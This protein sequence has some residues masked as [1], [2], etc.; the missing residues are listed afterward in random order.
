MQLNKNDEFFMR[1]ALK[2]AQKAAEIGEIPVGAVIV[3]DNKIIAKAHNQTQ[4]L[5]DPTA[6]AEMICITAACHFM[7]AKYL[8]NS[9]LYV[10]LE[11]CVMCAGAIKWAQLSSIIYGASDTKG[12]FNSVFKSDFYSKKTKIISG[13]LSEECGEILK[14]FFKNKR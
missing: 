14:L 8:I 4:L 10:T 11:P 2:E 1:A 12:G 6:H 9:S 3:L 7:G 5:N 13:I